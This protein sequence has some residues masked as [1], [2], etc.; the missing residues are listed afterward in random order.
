MKS[1]HSSKSDKMKVINPILSEAAQ[2][3]STILSEL[4]EE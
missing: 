2:K 3:I 4:T 1:L